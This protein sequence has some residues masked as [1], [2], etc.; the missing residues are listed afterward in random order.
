MQLISRSILLICLYYPL[1]RYPFKIG[2]EI[3][4]DGY[5]D[6]PLILQVGK[7]IIIG[8]LTAVL[9]CGAL[10]RIRTLPVTCMLYVGLIPLLFLPATAHAPTIESGVFWLCGAALIAYPVDSDFA[11]RSLRFFAWFSFAFVAMQITLFLTVGR[12]PAVSIEDSIAIRFGGPWDDPNGFSIAL[13]LFLPLGWLTLRGFKRLLFALLGLA[14]LLVTQ[15]LTGITAFI[16]AVSAGTLVLALLG[17]ARVRISSLLLLMILAAAAAGL[18]VI[19]IASAMQSGLIDE[20]MALKSGSIE[21]HLTGVDVLRSASI[22][23]LIGLQPLNRWGEMGYVNWLVNFGA[24]YTLVHLGLLVAMAVTAAFRRGPLHT[25]AFIFLIAY[26]AGLANLP[27]DCVFPVNMLAIILGTLQIAS[28]PTATSP[29][30]SCDSYHRA[31]TPD[32]GQPALVATSCPDALT[33]NVGA[34]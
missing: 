16:G 5:R 29:T 24:P 26:I 23:N 32:A 18:A 21:G 13:S 19:V 7:Y 8:A 10:R 15:S 28:V 34:P 14:A 3:V 12:L 22:E 30:E 6:T 27:L 4:S 11:V 25:A 2:D 1:Y 20:Y 31:V 9:L 17:F 33:E